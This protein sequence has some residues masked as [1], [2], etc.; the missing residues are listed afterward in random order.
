MIDHR[1]NLTA[2]VP[3]VSQAIDIYNN[4][5]LN[6]ERLKASKQQRQQS[7]ELLPL[8]KNLLTNQAERSATNNEILQG[9][10]QDAEKAR[11]IVTMTDYFMTELT[12]AI[13]T[14]DSE[15]TE[16][17]LINAANDGTLDEDDARNLLFMYRNG[18]LEGI[19]RSIDAATGYAKQRG[20]LGDNSNSRVQ[21][22]KIL[23]DG[24]TVQVKRSGEVLVTDPTGQAVTGQER[25][26]I[27]ERARQ[28]EAEQ[29]RNVA[30]NK[31]AGSE[32]AK[33]KQQK[34]RTSINE[35]VAAADGTAVIR[36]SLELLKGIETGGID[37]VQQ[38]VKQVF[39]VEG[40]D[41]GELSANLGKAVL[42][43]LR[44]IF[45]AAFTEREGARLERIEAGFGKSTATNKRLL[46]QLLKMSEREAKRG[47]RAA[48]Q[49]N[50]D[51]SYTEIEEALKFEVEPEITRATP[52]TTTVGGYTVEVI[53]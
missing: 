3:Q 4:T 13:E 50:D 2:Q 23:P 51:F 36:R 20:L 17:S 38:R 44:S 12:P 52:H 30:A 24:S 10:Q 1:I 39:G 29:A 15:R 21:S 40:A 35:G 42:S 34:L 46:E 26:N 47:M 16:N 37:A 5:L 14:G 28:V 45:G 11:K 18:D 8:R 41:E 7:E 33:G 25:S 6:N 22:S 19:K 49:A 9:Q 43:Q 31:S 27:L 32:N 53:E 48:K